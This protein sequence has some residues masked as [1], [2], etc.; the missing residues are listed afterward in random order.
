M[1]NLKPSERKQLHMFVFSALQL[2]PV[3]CWKAHRKPVTAENERRRENDHNG[4]RAV[5]QPCSIVWNHLRVKAEPY[6]NKTARALTLIFAFLKQ[7][8]T[9]CYWARWTV[10]WEL[11]LYLNN[12]LLKAMDGLFLC[13]T[14][15][16]ISFYCKM[17]NTLPLWLYLEQKQCCC[18]S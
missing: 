15:L 4:R 16:N 2:F 18:V 11:D 13:L 9:L 7:M 5:L 1:A 8:S 10:W 6:H 14:A 3:F 17:R 12:S